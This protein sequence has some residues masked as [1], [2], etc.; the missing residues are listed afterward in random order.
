MNDLALIYGAY[1]ALLGNQFLDPA[2]SISRLNDSLHTYRYFE[3]KTVLINQCVYR[4]TAE[5]IRALYKI[6]TLKIPDVLFNKI[7]R[8]KTGKLFESVNVDNY[9]LLL[10]TH[11]K[12]LLDKNVCINII[13]KNLGYQ[14]LNDFEKRYNFLLPQELD[15]NFQIL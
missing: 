7:P 13:R 10:N 9:D 1:N 5:N 4:G 15:D 3:N 12:L 2:D 11:I 6:R 14:C 8:N